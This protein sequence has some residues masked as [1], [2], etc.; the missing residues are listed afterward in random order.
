MARLALAFAGGAALALLPGRFSLPA[1]LAILAGLA[2]IRASRSRAVRAA[3]VVAVAAG[4]LAGTATRR[5]GA[6]EGPL[7]ARAAA[8]APQRPPGRAEAWRAVLV[9]RLDTLYGPHAPLVA[10]LTLAH[11][12]GLDPAVRDT[13]ARSGTAHLLAISGFH[14]GVVAGLLLTLLRGAGVRPRR[15]GVVAAG[16]AW[17]YVALLGF[18]DAA[19]R[20]ALILSA[21]A[22]SRARGRPPARWGALGSALLVLVAL[23]PARLASP[24]FQLSFAGAA[25]LVGWARPVQAWLARQLPRRTPEEFTSAVAA[26]VAATVATLPIVAWHFERVALVGIPATLVATPLVVLALPGAL[27]SLA[28]HA[29]HPAAGHFLAGGTGVAL[30]GL[31]WVARILSAPEWASVWVPRGWVTAGIAGMLLTGWVAGSARGHARRI[32]LAGGVSAGIVAWPALVTLQGRGTVELLMVDVGQGDAIAVRTP[33]GRWVLV[34]AGPPWR[35]DPGAAPLVRA[36]RRRGVQ[37]LEALVLT[38]PDL[39]HI[40]GATAVLAS[41]PVL[42]IVDPAVPAGKTP[43]VALLEEAERRGIPWR[44]AGQ[45]GRLAWDGVELTVLHPLAGGGGLVGGDTES[46]DAS[47]VMSLT[48]GD[49]DALLTGDAPAAVERHVLPG[50]SATLELLKVGHHGSR[51][52]TAPELLAHARPRVA[53]IS[54]GRRNRFGHPAT[55]VLARLDEHGVEVRRTDREGTLAVRARRDGSFTVGAPR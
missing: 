41:F 7:P 10:A 42:Q 35:G 16:A 33:A 51:T 9:A 4:A 24:G 13:F 53:L 48:F 32:V 28:A 43:Y 18:P 37:R 1:L 30:A 26:G 52:S 6:V 29:V 45:V 46:N 17:L 25:G 19:T 49:F 38:H 31:A 54:V 39:D 47:V 12:R 27:V 50:V 20:A 3:L 8:A 21:V 11:T 36:L 14:V 44:G 15:A 34:D 23:D 22:L 40:G 2:P 55:E 5:G